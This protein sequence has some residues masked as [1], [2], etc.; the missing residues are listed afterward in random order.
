MT[1]YQINNCRF[2]L[3]VYEALSHELWP[4]YAENLKSNQKVNSYTKKELLF[5]FTLIT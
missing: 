2:Y 5:Y 3:R 1:I 4:Y